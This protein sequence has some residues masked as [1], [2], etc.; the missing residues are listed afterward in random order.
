MLGI[1]QDLPP[2]LGTGQDLPPMFGIGQDLPPM[3]G[4][5]Q[6]LPPML[7]TGQEKPVNFV[8][9]VYSEDCTCFWVKGKNEKAILQTNIDD[10]PAQF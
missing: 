9:T 3:L 2:M 5:G 10:L 6:D 8:K 4:T 1:G 7:G